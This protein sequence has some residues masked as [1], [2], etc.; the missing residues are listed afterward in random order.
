MAGHAGHDA[1]AAATLLL[2]LPAPRAAQQ[3]AR[4]G[5]P[6]QRGPL[7]SSKPT[8][9]TPR[10]GPTATWRS[11]SR[12]CSSRPPR[13]RCWTTLK[14]CSSR[15]TPP[16]SCCS[17]P[18]YVDNALLWPDKL[19]RAPPRLR[20]WRAASWASCR[21]PTRAAQALDETGALRM[22]YSRRCGCVMT[23]HAWWHAAT[24]LA[25]GAATAARE[26]A[27]AR[28]G[29]ARGPAESA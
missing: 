20:R 28:T 23:S 19:F 26:V 9:S 15:P 2:R 27:I 16:R 29:A 24:L 22:C 10:C 6:L 5:L 8:A 1:T 11:R 12:P 17:P 13:C 14:G 4:R 3:D 7:A 21:S 18:P 25:V